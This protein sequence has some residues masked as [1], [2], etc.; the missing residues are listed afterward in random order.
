MSANVKVEKLK[1]IFRA[2]KGKFFTATFVKADG[3][4]RTLNGRT[5]VK[6]YLV[7]D[8]NP[9]KPWVDPMKFGNIVAFEYGV[10][11]RTFKLE[12]LKVVKIGGQVIDCSK[13]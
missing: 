4:E 1:K 7:P 10:G 9:N 8:T 11:Y 6:K 2:N 3:T 13:L 5:G 12:R